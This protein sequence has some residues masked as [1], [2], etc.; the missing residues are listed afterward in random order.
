MQL[1]VPFA[2]LFKIAFFMLLCFIVIRLQSLLLMV[3]MSALIAV[4]LQPLHGWLEK[5]L[6]R[7]VAT[8]LVA[9]LLIGLVLGFLV[10]VVPQT[11]AQGTELLK[12][13]P[14]I[15][16]RAIKAW[17]GGAPYIQSLMTEVQ[18]PP[19]PAQ[20]RQWM[21]RGMMAGRYAI[22][23]IAAILF[24]LVLAL[25]FVLDGKRLLAW[26]VTYAP[27]EQREKTT[28]TLSEVR[29]VI[30]AYMKGQL[31]TSTLSFIV[32]AVTLT[33]LGVPAALPLAVLAFIGDFI[34]VAGFIAALAPAVLL[35]LTVSPSAALTVIGVYVGYQM[36][37][38][39][40]IAPRIYG[41]ELEI[42]TVAVLLAI[43]FGGALIGP[44]GAILMLP[45]VSAWPAVEKIW[46]HDRL[47]EDTIEKH[48][49]LDRDGKSA[50][51]EI[52]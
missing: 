38:N 6:P 9:L 40:I 4:V 37:E 49:Q 19:Q 29:P 11:A 15:G 47:P 48:E 51:D 52:L 12:K 50:A 35:A 16:E 30:F 3:V 8:G 1:R 34:P 20:V 46:F 25:Y 10:G 14:Q 45:F 43:A 41:K 31:I 13:L 23:A 18:K 21:T 36:I 28:R 33:L 44:I 17:P 26:L 32:A 7:A 42:S 5:R 22:G 27:H 2:T 24:T 39:Y